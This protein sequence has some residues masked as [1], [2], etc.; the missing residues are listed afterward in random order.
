MVGGT[1]VAIRVVAEWQPAWPQPGTCEGAAR[2]SPAPCAGP[3]QP[4]PDDVTSLFCNETEFVFHLFFDCLVVNV[5]CAAVI[6]SLWTIRNDMCFQG[7]VWSNIQT[8]L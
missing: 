5:A 6:W 2:L 7:V 8:P 1:F 4:T 3:P